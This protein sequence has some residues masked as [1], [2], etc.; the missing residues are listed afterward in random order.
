MFVATINF[1]VKAQ[2]ISLKLNTQDYILSIEKPDNS[3]DLVFT[4][5]H[6][7]Q[8]DTKIIKGG[9]L[10]SDG[11]NCYY[12][13]SKDEVCFA[14]YFKTAKPLKD[15][16]TDYYKW[17]GTKDEFEQADHFVHEKSVN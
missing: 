12:V 15:N 4:E 7:T 11:D 1:Q 17:I 8:K 10:V 5:R 9:E 13:F 14:V 6:R 2:A 16:F 3:V